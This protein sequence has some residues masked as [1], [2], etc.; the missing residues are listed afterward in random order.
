MIPSEIR[1][2]APVFFDELDRLFSKNSAGEVQIAE[3][4]LKK[5]GDGL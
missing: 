1:S 4:Y 5:D 2:L 3:F